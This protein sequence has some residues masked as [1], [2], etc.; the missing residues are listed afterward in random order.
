MVAFDLPSKTVD[1]SSS[2]SL[3]I[4]QLLFY[5]CLRDVIFSKMLF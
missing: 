3:I 2:P 5:F 4:L 1:V